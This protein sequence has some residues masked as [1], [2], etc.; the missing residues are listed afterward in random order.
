MK[1]IPVKINGVDREV[2]EGTTLAVLVESLGLAEGRIAC[3]VNR[4]VIRRKNYGC[5]T[6]KFGDIVEVVQMIGGG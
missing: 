5:T 2:S 3:E 4:E 6:L 1:G